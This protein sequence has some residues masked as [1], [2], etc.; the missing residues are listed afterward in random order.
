[1]SSSPGR[2]RAGLT[3]FEVLAAVLVLGLLYTALAGVAMTGLRSEGTDRRRAEA[4]M[5]V[6]HE[7]ASIEALLAAGEVLE[8]GVVEREAEPYTVVVDVQPVDV[9][10][11]LPAP[12]RE[13]V[14]RNADPD[15]PSLLVDEQGESRV[16]RLTIAVE[17]DEA[18]ES[19]RVERIT[20]AFD[21]SALAGFF[22]SEEP[23]AGEGEGAESE[24]SMS[25]LR[26][27]APAELQSLIDQAGKGER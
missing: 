19:A 5:M 21:T 13:E 12:V 14:E 8:L 3:L 11:L 23:A 4:A 22:P 26:K 20:Y 27:Q 9:L 24:A 2:R 6:D 15:A 16:Q 17:W 1:M 7:L 10:E 25:E 18:G